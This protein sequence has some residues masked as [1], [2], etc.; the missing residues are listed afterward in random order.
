MTTRWQTLRRWLRDHRLPVSIA[1][2]AL[3]V[4]AVQVLQWW[5]APASKVSDFVGPP[6]SGYTLHQYQGI[7]YDRDGK[8][9]FRIAGPYLERREGDESL[10][11]TAPRFELPAKQ[12]GVPDWQGH[13]LYGWVDKSGTLIKLQGAVHMHR[14]AYDDV[15]AIDIDTSDITAW[16]K[17][18]RM[19]TAAP[20]RMVQGDTRMS[21]V[22]MRA[23]LNDNHLELLDD[24]Q[25]TFPPRRH[26]S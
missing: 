3:A 22:G 20:V 18:N 4:I 1:A 13:S 19:E 10:Y 7:L 9:S 24:S 2:M 15:A 5:L 23:N 25:G 16:P 14:P 6:R 17:E 26:K 21:G 8:P 11:L 12:P